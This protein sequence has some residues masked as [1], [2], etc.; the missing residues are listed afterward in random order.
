VKA[1]I[2]WDMHVFIVFGP[3][4]PMQSQVIT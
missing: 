1:N 2:V 3:S 4:D